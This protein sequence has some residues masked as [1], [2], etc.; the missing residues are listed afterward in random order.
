MFLSCFFFSDNSFL[1]QE[2]YRS[3]VFIQQH[4]V[5]YLSLFPSIS[6]VVV[7][8]VDVV[9]SK[10]AVVCLHQPQSRHSTATLRM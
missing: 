1:A 10:F 2:T 8:A 7:V 4:L 5:F 3:R 9:K 6:V